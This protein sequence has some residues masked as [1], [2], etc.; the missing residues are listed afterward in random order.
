MVK[1]DEELEKDLSTEMSIRDLRNFSDLH[2]WKE[3]EHTSRLRS[4]GLVKNF[5]KKYSL[6]L[7]VSLNSG[8]RFRFT[9]P[10]APLAPLLPIMARSFVVASLMTGKTLSTA[11][12]NSPNV[13]GKANNGGREKGSW[14]D[15]N[16]V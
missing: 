12:L 7:L 16:V 3:C 13:L 9:L 8:S 4:S 5:A 11:S 1:E 2:I 15:Q 10:V 14:R 6:L